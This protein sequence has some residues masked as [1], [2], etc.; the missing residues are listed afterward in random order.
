MP[1]REDHVIMRVST[2]VVYN[3][4][5]SGCRIE[6]RVKIG[7]VDRETSIPRK[8]FQSDSNIDFAERWRHC[9]S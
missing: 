3:A 2:C 8:Q 7:L 9:K 5:I 1:I 4:I 6:T